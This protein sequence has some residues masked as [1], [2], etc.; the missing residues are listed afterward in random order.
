MEPQRDIERDAGPHPDSAETDSDDTRPVVLIGLDGS[1]SS[2]HAFSWGCGEAR[3]MGGRVMTV[4]V[5]PSLS[6]VAGIALMLGFYTYDHGAA[7]TAVRQQAEQ[8]K[9]EALARAASAG[10][11]LTFLHARGDPASELS[12]IAREIHAD[13]TAVGR[14]TKLCHRFAGALGRR[15]LAKP[16]APIIVVVP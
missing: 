5:S 16:G 8:L 4:F 13:V 1:Q 3:R 2:W 7:E 14:S 15:L 10:I 11:E 9:A 6:L 12:R